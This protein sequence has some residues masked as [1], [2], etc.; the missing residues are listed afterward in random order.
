MGK[1]AERM[2]KHIS[3]NYF[4]ILG[5][6][7]PKRS[8]KGRMNFSSAAHNPEV[9]G[10]NPSPETKS[11]NFLAFG[12]KTAKNTVKTEKTGFGMAIIARPG[13]VFCVFGTKFPRT[14]YF[15]LTEESSRKKL[16]V[17]GFEPKNDMI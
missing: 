17:G 5:Q 11:G 7:R 14:F 16:A 15:K 4:V 10:S 12:V 9:V 13:S 2:G 8:K 6:N 1:R 3:P